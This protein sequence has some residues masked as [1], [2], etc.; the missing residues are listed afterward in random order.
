MKKVFV[1]LMVLCFIFA[2]S[3]FA[4][5]SDNDP[6][7][8]KGGLTSYQ[9]KVSLA[10]DAEILLPT[11]V[12]GFGGVLA[13]DGEENI[14]V[15]FTSAGAVTKVTWT[16]NATDSDSDGNLCVYDKG[17]GI[18]VKNRLGSTKI[19]RFAFYYSK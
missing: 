4:G 2:G 18:A 13:G 7:S 15:Y 6:F 3:A 19:I 14:G 9:L 16:T 17:S 5:W 10:D 11:G 12:A 1:I 8:F